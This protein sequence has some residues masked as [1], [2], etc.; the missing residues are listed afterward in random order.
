[1]NNS[2]LSKDILATL[3]VSLD[4]IKEAVQSMKYTFEQNET[5]TYQQ[6][7]RLIEYDRIITKQQRL[8]YKVKKIVDKNPLATPDEETYRIL[9][10]VG[11]LAL[12]MQ[13]DS[14]DLYSE[15]VYNTVNYRGRF[16][17]A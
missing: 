11:Q 5:I 14:Q 12:M 9:H 16:Y 4:T 7:L 8:V 1:M 13:L 17:D 2:I 6:R 15:I 3:E 10:I